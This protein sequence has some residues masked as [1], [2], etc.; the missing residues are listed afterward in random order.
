MVNE[1]TIPKL[2]VAIF[3]RHPMGQPWIST[4]GVT[5]KSDF[6]GPIIGWVNPTNWR[7]VQRRN[8]RFDRASATRW[9][10][11]HLG[12]CLDRGVKDGLLAGAQGWRPFTQEAIFC[13]YQFSPSTQFPL[14]LH[15]LRPRVETEIEKQFKGN[16]MWERF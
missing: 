2:I 14:A 16:S 13:S 12:D 11:Q 8:P 7:G 5:R 3:V 10:G 15:F 1:H 4:G 9:A 6:N